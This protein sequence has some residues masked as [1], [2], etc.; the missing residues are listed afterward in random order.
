M[1]QTMVTEQ[2][3]AEQT[4]VEDATIA[5]WQKDGLIQSGGKGASGTALFP[6]QMVARVQHIRQLLDLGYSE[7]EV[8]RILRKV[9]PPGVDDTRHPSSSAANLL[10]VGALA[11]SV[12]VSPRTIKHWEDKGI[13]QA[14]ARSDGGFRL[15]NEHYIYL[16]QLVQ[17]LQ[18]FN[19]SLEQIK[20]ISD[21]FRDFLSMRQN[22]DSFEP[23]SAAIRL[24]QMVE[25]ID[26]LFSRTTKLREG[27]DRWEKLLN[28]HRKLIAELRKNNTRRLQQEQK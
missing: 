4:G 18:L 27:I 25:E 19:Y 1:R 11:E 15:F 24:D 23:S 9:G 20:Q 22:L 21:Y 16:C 17:D 5:R 26:G 7:E 10:T 8:N 28:R 3:L 12:G 6:E 13:I 2:E 14:D